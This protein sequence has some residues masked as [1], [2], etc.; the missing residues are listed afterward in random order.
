MRLH[1]VDEHEVRPVGFLRAQPGQD[2]LFGQL[3][4]RLDAPGRQLAL[5]PLGPV[6]DAAQLVALVLFEQFLANDPGGALAVPRAPRVL[7]QVESLIE[8]SRVRNVG[9]RGI[10]VRPVLLMHLHLIRR[11]ISHLRVDQIQ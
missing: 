9:I 3:A 5:V 7:D 1:V 11:W 10:Q 4:G 2:G 8:V 6:E